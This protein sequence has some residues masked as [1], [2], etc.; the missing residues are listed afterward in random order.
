MGARE[1]A[2]V[3]LGVENLERDMSI[4]TMSVSGH[5][6]LKVILQALCEARFEMRETCPLGLWT[7]L[8][9]SCL[10]QKGVPRYPERTADRHGFA[11]NS[12][13]VTIGH[14]CTRCVNWA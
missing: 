6:C 14:K 2:S 8:P 7:V 13:D 9:R 1:F 10:A 12:T 3:E 5:G 11:R 4:C